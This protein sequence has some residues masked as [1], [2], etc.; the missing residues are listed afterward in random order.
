VTQLKGLM[1]QGALSQ[2]EFEA[3]KQKV[4]AG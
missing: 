4:L 2:A 3:A 1:D